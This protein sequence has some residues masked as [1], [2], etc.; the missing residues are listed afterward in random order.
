[1]GI[2]GMYRFIEK[3][4]DVK[5]VSENGVIGTVIKSGLPTENEY[6]PVTKTTVPMNMNEHLFLDFNGGIYTAFHNNQCTTVTSLINNTIGYFDLLISLYLDYNRKINSQL[7]TVFLAIDGIP[8]RAKIEQQ[9]TRRFHSIDEKNTV[10]KLSDKYNQTPNQPNPIDTNMITP[11]TEFME[12]LHQKLLQHFIVIQNKYPDINFIYSGYNEPLEGE[13]KLL[14]YIKNNEWKKNDRIII[15]GLDA[16]LIMLSMIASDYIGQ[17]GIYLLREKTE[18]GNL[19][20]DYQGSKFLYLDINMTKSS[21]LKEF[22]NNL[23]DIANEN[24]NGFMD[25]FVFFC[26][27]LGN[28]FV[29][30]IAHL[31][32]DNSGG[33]TLMTVY[34]NVYNMYREFLVD[35]ETMKINHL[36]LLRLFEELKT[37]E[38]DDMVKYHKHRQRR[39]INMRQI[40]NEYDRQMQLMKF[41]PLKHLYVEKEIDPANVGWENRY[42]KI[43]FNQTPT[44]EFKETVVKRYLE[45]LVWTFRYYFDKV[46]SWSWFYPYHYGPL[47]NDVF[48][49]LEKMSNKEITTP[50]NNI[51]QIKFPKG[52]PVKPQ[53]LLAM[54]LPYSSRHLMATG[55]QSEI[56]NKNNPLSKYFPST[57]RMSLPYHSFYWQCRPILP[58]INY[59]IVEEEI[60]KIKLSKNEQERNIN[61]Y[62][63]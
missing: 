4:N 44:D 13:H 10:R 16:D 8:P 24:I 61:I 60:K 41:F 19:S 32:L 55:I 62:K 46:D 27:I 51:N 15:Y 31:A 1:M 30:H 53:E 7:K 35:R 63:S 33:D 50:I 58:I 18:Y 17:G 36:I 29:P 37:T 38:R 22:E 59:K 2:P 56:T 5:Y 48:Q 47:C 25:D 3:Y 20:F 12:Q 43:C 42:Y 57:Y 52:R 23:G 49:Y 39:K 11:G 54:V 6:E 34:C 14:Q 40:T 26:F 28:D 21:L 45:S 9:R